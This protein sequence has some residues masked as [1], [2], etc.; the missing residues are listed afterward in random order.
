[1]SGPGLQGGEH[2]STPSAPVLSL[3]LCFLPNNKKEMNKNHVLILGISRQLLLQWLRQGKHPA[4]NKIWLSKWNIIQTQRVTS[5]TTDWI[6]LQLW[7]CTFDE[8]FPSS[9]GTKGWLGG[10]LAPAPTPP[11]K[12]PSALSSP[13]P[14]RAGTP[15][16]LSKQPTPYMPIK[17]P[18]S[19]TFLATREAQEL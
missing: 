3:G 11:T 15:A 8:A 1:M 14:H 2:W 12:F 4:G 19:P 16:H 5:R 10:T 9:D 17:Q 7:P 13:K 18:Y 6:L